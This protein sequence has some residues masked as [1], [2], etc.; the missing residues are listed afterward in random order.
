[1]QAQTLAQNTGLLECWNLLE[2]HDWP[3]FL[4]SAPNRTDLL[5]SGLGYLFTAPGVPIVYYGLE[6][7]FN[8]NCGP[9]QPSC[10]AAKASVA[11]TCASGDDSLKRQDMFAS[12]PWRLES[13][14]ADVDMLQGIGPTRHALSPDWRKDR[15]LQPG[16]VFEVARTLSALRRSCEPLATGSI[17]WRDASDALGGFLAFSRIGLGGQ[18]IV[19]I[20]NPGGDSDS[21]L[22][23]LGKLT[24]GDSVTGRRYV[25]A[26]NP[27]Q[28]ATT[29]MDG[30]TPVLIFAQNFSIA[31]GTTAVFIHEQDLDAKAE[32][33]VSSGSA[34]TT[35]TCRSRARVKA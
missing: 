16:P 15:F 26:L 9:L 12:G 8:G 34:G 28:V 5:M 18:E 14:V 20:V 21:G 4:A 25:N 1:M 6:Q 3:R 31:A 19:V 29:D 7:G 27:R 33:A 2:I 30:S 35:L 23:S 11:A 17:V 32:P 22:L 13:S 10:G 24:V